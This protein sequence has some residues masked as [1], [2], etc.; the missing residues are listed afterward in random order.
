LIGV[1][2]LFTNP[3]SSQVLARTIH[4][5]D[6]RKEAAGATELTGKEQ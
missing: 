4:L 1:F 5:K 6:A 3:V 2:L